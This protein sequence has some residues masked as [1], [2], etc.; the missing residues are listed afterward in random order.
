MA[1]GKQTEIVI[2][3]SF[4][5]SRCTALWNSLTF[6]SSRSRFVQFYLLAVP[7]VL[8][9]LVFPPKERLQKFILMTYYNPDKGS[10]SDWLKRISF[11]AP[12]IRSTTQIWV[13]I[14]MAFLR[15][16][17][18]RQFA[19]ASRNVGCFLRLLVSNTL[20]RLLRSTT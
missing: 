4:L 15:S 8:R 2:S 6:L 14:S 16:F 19:M 5:V 7:C 20:L 3:L 1:T 13:V 11:A 18:S 9:P 12:P 10:V 17:L